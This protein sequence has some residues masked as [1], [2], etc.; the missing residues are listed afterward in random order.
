MKKLFVTLATVL[1]LGTVSINAQDATAEPTKMQQVMESHDM[2]MDKM[3]TI[4]KLIN[5]LQTRA[6]ASYEKT[7]YEHAIADLK[8]ANKSM[9]T[10]MEN[11][12]KRFDS[13]EML[14]GKQLTPQK[15]EWLLEEEKNIAV[16]D[17]EINLSIA[18]G[19][20]TLDN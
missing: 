3:P 1:V 5:K 10:W 7:K 9:M 4:S 18:Q 8:N 12:G 17:E 6:N 15:Q 20:A 2:V 13:K 14:K 16:L 11:F 19:E